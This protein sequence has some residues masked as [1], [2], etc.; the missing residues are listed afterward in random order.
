MTLAAS[1]GILLLAEISRLATASEALSVT[2]FTLKPRLAPQSRQITKDKFDAL[3]FFLFRM[4]C[5]RA[6]GNPPHY[7]TS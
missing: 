1:T 3:V 6:G 7:F 5:P 2:S 4:S